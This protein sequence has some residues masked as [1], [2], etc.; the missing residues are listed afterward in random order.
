MTTPTGDNLAQNIQMTDI[1]TIINSITPLT[2]KIGQ[3]EKSNNQLTT[4]IEQLESSNKQLSEQVLR[5]EIVQTENLN[6]LK[7][8]HQNFLKQLADTL[9]SKK[10]SSLEPTL[11]KLTAALQMFGSQVKEQKKLAK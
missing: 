11:Q 9:N 10:L 7:A 5:L 8:S 6:E 2:K 3:L 4:K 1:K